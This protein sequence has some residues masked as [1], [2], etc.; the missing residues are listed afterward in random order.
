MCRT[1]WAVVR[2]TGAAWCCVLVDIRVCAVRNPSALSVQYDVLHCGAPLGGKAEDLRKGVT[3]AGGRP[4]IYTSLSLL[5]I[6]ATVTAS[7]TLGTVGGFSRVRR[8]IPA[9]RSGDCI[10]QPIVCRTCREVRSAR[11][12]LLLW[13]GARGQFVKHPTSPSHSADAGDRI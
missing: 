11:C 4:C 13:S 8:G 2:W 3:G 5:C 7:R 10:G 9:A 6:C 12:L 1:G